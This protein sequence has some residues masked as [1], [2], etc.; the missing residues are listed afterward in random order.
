MHDNDEHRSTHK[1]LF[2]PVS[3]Y[4]HTVKYGLLDEIKMD[5]DYTMTND[6][7]EFVNR[8]FRFIKNR[9]YTQTHVRQVGVKNDEGR[10]R[11]KFNIDPV[12]RRYVNV[13]VSSRHEYCNIMDIP[14]SMPLNS[15][16]MRRLSRPSRSSYDMLSQ[17][18]KSSQPKCE[19]RTDR[20]RTFDKVSYDVPTS[21]C[22]TV[23]AK[24][25]HS[26]DHSKFAVMIKKLSSST[27]K[28][29]LKIVTQN[30]K[31]VMR[32]KSDDKVEC[33]LNGDKKPCSELHT[34]KT[35]GDHVVLR[36]HKVQDT[37]MECE[38]PEA[39][40]RV[41]FDGL[42]ANIKV[43][44]WYRSLVCGLCGHYNNEQDD[45]LVSADKRH[46]V[47]GEQMLR[48]YLIEEDNKQC[49]H[50]FS[51]Y[52]TKLSW[53]TVY[54]SDYLDE[55]DHKDWMRQ[56]LKSPV[57]RTD[58]DIDPIKRT[59]VIEQ[60]D[61]ICFSKHPVPKCPHHTYTKEHKS[62]PEK[63][64]Y[65]CLPRHSEKAEKYHR[66]TSRDHII[67]EIDSLKPS[68]TET[69]YVPKSCGKDY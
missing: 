32:A 66:R 55:H 46:L 63:I 69:E 31:L 42:S 64:V 26:S 33:H 14:M 24:D 57:H 23:L 10:L 4:K 8:L 49:E 44:P 27:E 59:K 20:V 45:D 60:S 3:Q 39:G 29:E 68:F 43:S 54:D 38:L 28:K 40:I 6:Q 34:I 9:Y 15:L 56:L 35:H 37:Y 67:D 47:S 62:Q 25:C 61:E 22:Y 53:D 48:S 17:Y 41:Y 52:E 11:I 19:V 18:T 21:T 1:S 13:S 12:S 16:N 30:V 50:Q 5:V 51:Q 7:Q 2:S 36:C 65:C 58:R